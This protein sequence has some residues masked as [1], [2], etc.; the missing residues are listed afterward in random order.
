M[1]FHHV[2]QDGLELLT[3]DDPPTSASQ[4]VGITGMSH[5]AWPKNKP[6]ILKDSESQ[7]DNDSQEIFKLTK[8]VLIQGLIDENPGLQYVLPL[9][10]WVGTIKLETGF[11]YVGQAGLE[12]LISDD[13]PTSAFQKVV[14]LLS[15][16]LEYNGTILVHCHLH[17][18]D[19]SDSPASASRIAG[20]TSTCHHASLIFVFLVQMGFHRVGQASLELLTSG[21]PP[22]S[23]SQSAGVTGWPLLSLPSSQPTVDAEFM[24]CRS[25]LNTGHHGQVSES[26][27][28]R[29]P[30]SHPHTQDLSQCHVH[31]W[32][33]TIDSDWRFRSTVLT[34][35]FVETQ[36]SQGT[37][38]TRTQEG[39]VSARW[40]T[41]GQIRA[42]QQHYDFT[43]TQTAV[44]FSYL[45]CN[46]AMLAHCN[47]RLSGSSDSL[48]S[49]SQVAG[50][51]D[52]RSSFD[53]LTGSSTDP[54]ADHTSPSSDSLLFAHKRSERSQRVPL[55][56]VGPDFGKKR[57]GLPGDE[58]D[59]KVK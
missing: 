35:M 7:T 54:L 38:Q 51:T 31:V 56:S 29:A 53:W 43:P 55:K 10:N 33:Y 27:W 22:T 47:L 9:N 46:G 4:S 59:N 30:L 40:S 58:V 8:D 32:E 3:S 49:A 36:V 25:S 41:A 48:A 13:P 21:D 16:M 12:L 57:L 52:G 50:T 18:L 15:L 42:T 34:P 23:A 39:S 19:S 5:Y 6:F 2:G 20:I 26:S 17:C 28:G 1:R 24:L 44:S 14:S 45:E 11:H 37:L